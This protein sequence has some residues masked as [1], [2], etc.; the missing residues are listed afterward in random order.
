MIC[1]QFS[2]KNATNYF[3]ALP[4]ANAL[5]LVKLSII[6]PKVDLVGLLTAL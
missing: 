3:T 5:L 6:F 4:E 2:C 1:C